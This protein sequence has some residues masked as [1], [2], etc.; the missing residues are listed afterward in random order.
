MNVVL[1]DPAETRFVKEMEIKPERRRD[2]MVVVLAPPG[3]LVGKF[4][5][6]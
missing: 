6:S 1:N 5:A 2:S 4:P 3:V